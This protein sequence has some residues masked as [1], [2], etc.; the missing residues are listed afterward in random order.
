M[1][2]TKKHVYMKP[3]LIFAISFNRAG[4]LSPKFYTKKLRKTPK[5]PLINGTSMVALLPSNFLH[6]NDDY[7]ETGLHARAIITLKKK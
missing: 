6:N 2:I 4:F 5:I 3:Y 1:V 7:K